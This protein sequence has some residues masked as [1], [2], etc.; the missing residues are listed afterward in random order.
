MRNN[1]AQVTMYIAPLHTEGEQLPSLVKNQPK[2]ANRS[3][4]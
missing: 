2:G 3:Y 1:A 4:R